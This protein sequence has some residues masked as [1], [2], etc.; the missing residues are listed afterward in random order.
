M[1]GGTFHFRALKATAS[2]AVLSKTHTCEKCA[3]IRRY[4]S[5]MPAAYRFIN[6]KNRIQLYGA[7]TA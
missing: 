6:L 5:D 1:H 4:E 2:E 7:V 3:I